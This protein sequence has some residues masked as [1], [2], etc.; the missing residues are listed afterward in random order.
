[1]KAVLDVHYGPAQAHAVCLAFA[2]WTD[3]RPARVQSV[4]LPPPAPYVPGRF[5]LRELPCLLAV[6][7]AAGAVFAHILVDGYTHLKPPAVKGLGAH[8]ADA[9]ERE[10]IVIGVAKN[11]LAMADRFVP[12]TR[13]RSRR[14]LYVSAVNLALEQAADLVSSMHGPFRIPTLIR[15]ADRT[16]RG[17]GG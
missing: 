8:L 16:A 11:P 3:E 13:G 10:C 6:L 17:L 7:E 14:P 12:V 1:M 2:S 5:F 15:K 9:L 4:R